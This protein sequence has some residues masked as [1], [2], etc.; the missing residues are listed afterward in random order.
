MSTIEAVGSS[1]CSQDITAEDVSGWHY[2]KASEYL[3]SIYENSNPFYLIPSVVHLFGA[4]LAKFPG[5]SHVICAASK[6]SLPPGANY[7]IALNHKNYRRALEL[8][9]NGADL[10]ICNADGKNLVEL[11]YDSDDKMFKEAARLALQQNHSFMIND[12]E[13]V[14]DFLIKR[15]KKLTNLIPFLSE[16]IIAGGVFDSTHPVFEKLLYNSLKQK[17]FELSAALIEKGVSFQ[18]YVVHHYLQKL[19]APSSKL[20]SPVDLGLLEPYVEDLTDKAENGKFSHLKTREVCLKKL[21]QVLLK[22]EKNHP[23]IYGKSGCGKTTLVDTLA[24][25][26]ATNQLPAALAGKRVL[27]LDGQKLLSDIN[28]KKLSIDALHQ[29]L[30]KLDGQSIIFIDNLQYLLIDSEGSDLD[31]SITSLSDL[32]RCLLEHRGIHWIS[33][34]NDTS[35]EYI[36]RNSYI[37]LFFSEFNLDEP[38]RQESLPI[39]KSYGEKYLSPLLNIS[40]DPEIYLDLIDLCKRFVPNARFPETPINVLIRCGFL[41]KNQQEFGPLKIQDLEES[42]IQLKQQID[43]EQENPS[44]KSTQR[45]EDLEEKSALKEKEIERLEE[46]LESEQTL[47]KRKTEVEAMLGFLSQLVKHVE[48]DLAMVNLTPH[49]EKLE[50]EK[51]SL[52]KELDNLPQRVFSE[53]V[54]KY[55]VAKVISELSGVPLNKLNTNEKEQLKELEAKLQ[56][57][58]KGQEEAIKAVAD[59][60]RRSRLG[61]NGGNRPRGT[62]LF[63]GPTG[64]GKTEL[65]KALAEELLG[66]EDHMI[67]IDMSEFQHPAD[68]NRLIGSAPGYVGYGE[69]GKLTEALKKKPY[70]VVLIDELEKAHPTCIDVFLQ[71]FDDG[72]LTDGQG[73]TINCKEAV[74]IM[75]SN[76]GAKTYSLP[77]KEMQKEALDQALK[78]TLRPEFINRIDDIL[79]FNPLDKKEIVRNIAKLQLENLQEKVAKLFSITLSWDEEVIEY[80]TEKGFSPLFGARPLRNLVEKQLMTLISNALLE[81]TLQDGGNAHFALE[82]DQVSLKVID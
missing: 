18:P 19:S 35:K 26:A 8:A 72:R 22:N 52:Q 17:N 53:S 48:E 79:R 5:V 51:A 68:I 40:I 58:I 15:P 21:I 43:V 65:A 60:I 50:T 2:D 82:E 49:I 62:F 39:V 25:A 46:T 12:N 80:L 4:M 3:S 66:S 76:I 77:T 67:R 10:S 24:V 69:G 13:N 63:L 55:V 41:V 44:K 16:L 36:E 57:R 28:K 75:T 56:Q 27:S 31:P 37:N 32:F 47:L 81:D 71:V 30:N 61:L 70:S 9:R 78:E 42:L 14:V 38:S 11:L 59:T 64:V 74:F 45:V 54:D 7:T 29:V 6:S 1:T 34:S 23:M 33:S 20:P 73:E